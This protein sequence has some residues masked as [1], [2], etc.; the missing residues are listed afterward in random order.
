MLSHAGYSPGRHLPLS[1][2]LAVLHVSIYIALENRKKEVQG[3]IKQ[4]LH[5]VQW[6]DSAEMAVSRVTLC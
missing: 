5:L 6:Q 1:L 3:C 2:Y 4:L